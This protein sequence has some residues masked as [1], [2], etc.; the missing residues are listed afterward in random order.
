MSRDSGKRVSASI[1]GGE[2]AGWTEVDL[3]DDRDHVY[4]VKV[5]TIEGR[6]RA[7]GVAVLPKPDRHP[8]L[9]VIDGEALRS[10]PVSQLVAAATEMQR[11]NFVE[12]LGEA[13]RPPRPGPAGYGIEHWQAVGEVWREARARGASTRKAIARHWGVKVSTADLWIRRA[14]DAGAIREDD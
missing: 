11:L 2:W 3:G 10:V 8:K 13:Q 5:S 6:P 4:R 7:T 14:K 9:R 12:A 1:L